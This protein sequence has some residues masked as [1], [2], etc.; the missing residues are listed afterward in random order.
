MANKSCLN[1][2]EHLCPSI[3]DDCLART[4]S[5]VYQIVQATPNRLYRTPY[6]QGASPSGLLW[7]TGENRPMH[8]VRALQ[9]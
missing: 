5:L 7:S 6:G 4:C 8:S 9:I 3:S 2:L 1:P